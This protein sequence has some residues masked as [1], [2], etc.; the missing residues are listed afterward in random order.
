MHDAISLTFDHVDRVLDSLRGEY[1]LGTREW[2]GMS[3]G[4]SRQASGSDDLVQCGCFVV[5]SEPRK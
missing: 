2:M 1:W 4:I 5:D 3:E